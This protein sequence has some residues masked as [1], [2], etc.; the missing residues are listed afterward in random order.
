[1][2]S[3]SLHDLTAAYALDALE[4]HEAQAYEAHLRDCERCRE[5]LTQLRQGAAALAFA[6]QSPQPPARL[7]A[8]I[9]DA[10][11]AERD[12]VMPLLRRSTPYRATAAFAAV[13][14]CGA[15]ALGTWAAT[16]HHALDRA[17]HAERSATSAAAILAD[18]S[19]LRV[20]LS[21]GNGLVAVDPAGQGV[22]VV[23]DLPSAPS[24]RTY[25][26]WVIPK[27][28]KPQRAG[29]FAGG[30]GATIVRL[31]ARVGRGDLVA[32]TVERAGGV[33]AP[34]TTPIFSAQ[35]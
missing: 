33:N 9:L 8:S 4:A 15:V 32:A 25:E 13:A 2:E 16:L 1:V 5:D 20:A 30:T 14:A 27:G 12:N 11:A 22:M 7:R 18:R 6:V 26:A 19:S 3:V 21:G 35:V 28:G 31:A 23:Q 34:T 24:G 17:R 29:L 10:A